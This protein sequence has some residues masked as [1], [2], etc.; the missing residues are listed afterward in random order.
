M[1][2]RSAMFVWL[3]TPIAKM[4]IPIVY[5][6]S[7]KIASLFSKEEKIMLQNGVF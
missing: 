5:K 3:P 6:N 7:L 2:D 4:L 1:A